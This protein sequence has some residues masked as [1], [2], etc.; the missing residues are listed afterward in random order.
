MVRE[1]SRR[2]S[3]AFK[4]LGWGGLGGLSLLLVGCGGITAL[5]TSVPPSPAS[6]T[7]PAPWSWISEP[8]AGYGPWQNALQHAQTGVDVN[9]YLLTDGRYA[10]QL[11]ALAAQGIPVQVL[12][13]ANPYHDTTAVATERA[14]F[15]GTRVQLHWAPDRFTQAYAF[16]HAKYLV[17]NPDTPHAL[18]IVGSP[19]GTWSAFGGG[20][21]EDALETTQP[22][23]TTALTKVFRADWTD[24]PAGSAPRQALVLSPGAQPSFLTLLAGTGPVA[25]TAEE[26]GD[27]P[28]LYAALAAHGAQGRLLIPTEALHSMEA[29]QNATLLVHAGVQIRTLT[30]P[31]LH[32]KLIVTVHHTWVGSQNWSESSMQNNREVGLIT[33]NAAIHQ[34]ALAWFNGLWHRAKPWP[35]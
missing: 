28:T 22:A 2:R 1:G 33:P 24:T 11:I 26:L 21:A 6:P 3:G 12:L 34:A 30:T 35:P 29:Q 23:I 8:Q 9:Q 19:N 31:Y 14:F 25:V 32:A 18:A 10:H 27:V 7:S 5:G 13:A 4:I 15:A 17:V 20:N 16:D